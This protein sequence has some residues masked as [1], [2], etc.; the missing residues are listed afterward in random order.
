[1]KTRYLLIL[2]PFFIIALLLSIAGCE[3]D[4]ADPLWDK[5]YVTPATPKV[6]QV[7]PAEALAGVNTI[8][9]NGE[10]FS[11]EGNV[12]YFDAITADVISNT[13]TSIIVRRPDIVTDSAKIKVIS[14]DAIV[15]AKYSPYK[16]EK[17]LEKYGS[18]LDNLQ[19]SVV[20]VDA[21]ENLYVVE[22]VS[23]AIIKV[24][25]DGEK[26]TVTN[27]NRTA[28]DATIGP[29]GNLYLMGNNRAIDQVN[30]TTGQISRW[31]QLPSGKVV[32]YGDFD[33]NG[34]FYT[35]GSKTDLLV[36]EPGLTVK[37]LSG[38][39]ANDDILT[40]RVSGNYVYV[41][42]RPTATENPL[43][44]W[45][46]AVDASGNL[47]IQELVLDMSTTGGFAS[48]LIK[49]LRFSTSGLMYLA[50]DSEDPILLFD[51]N[52]STL[53]YLYKNILTPYCKHFYWGTGNY[54]YMITGDS[55]LGEEWTV[56]RVNVGSE[57][58]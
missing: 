24:T 32:R 15:V 1:M 46:H 38:T 20:A 9:I 50:T 55:A 6:T 10:N 54:I 53:D 43:K 28:T 56:Y 11:A 7:D 52:T 4:V 14:N 23:R 31:I 19:L 2:A 17:I 58:Q 25:P 8:T 35:G 33:A 44:I 30:L 41:V 16:V 13:P 36:V 39:Y 26:S 40:V 27:A 3:Y 21:N 42:S 5:E 29:D 18:F 48:R 57:G 22:T 34:N 12:V 47:G 37:P 49:S 45:R 51:P